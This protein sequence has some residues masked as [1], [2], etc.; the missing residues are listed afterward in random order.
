MKE[1]YTASEIA[2]AMEVT[3]SAVRRQAKAKGWPYVTKKGRGRG[4]TLKEYKYNDLP[5]RVRLALKIKWVEEVKQEGAQFFK[6]LYRQELACLARMVLLRNE[7]E[8]EIA[9]TSRELATQTGD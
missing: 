5:R 2:R 8:A 9:N 1:T 4:G 6:S 7:L 3:D